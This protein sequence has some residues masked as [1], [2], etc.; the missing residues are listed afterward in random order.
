VGGDGVSVY[1][2]ADTTIE[3]TKFQSFPLYVLY[4]T[5]T[6]SDCTITGS[7]AGGLWIY[8]ATVTVSNCTISDNYEDL[9]AAGIMS[10]GDLTVRNSIISGNVSGGAGGGIHQ[11]WGILT[12]TD[13]TISGNV[14]RSGGGIHQYRG[15]LI[16]DNST[17]SGNSSS[18]G[19]GIFLGDSGDMTLT[20]TNSTIVGNY[21]ELP[22]ASGIFNASSKIVTVRNSIIADNLNGPDCYYEPPY[23]T[24]SS[25]GHNLDSDG[26]CNFN[27]PTDQPSAGDP[28]LGPLQD[29]GGPTWTHVP[30]EG[31]PVVDR[32]MCDP[33][34]DQRGVPRPIDGDRDSVW[35]CDIGA[36]EYVPYEFEVIGPGGNTILWPPEP[37]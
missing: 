25:L 10:V 29:N 35:L 4:S 6:L 22:S 27:H 20:L 18:V 1:G 36:V 26:T 28:M 31:S 33:G 16:V 11:H 37:E 7:R 24:I 13:S 32:G 34:T 14:A 21:A 8:S 12:I 5:V 19:G 15:D 2:A 9:W 3:G 17:I 23:S 30:L